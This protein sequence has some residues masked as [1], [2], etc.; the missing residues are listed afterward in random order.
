MI[1]KG[2][3]FVLI[4]STCLSVVGPVERKLRLLI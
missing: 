4:F 2:K 1:T 3:I